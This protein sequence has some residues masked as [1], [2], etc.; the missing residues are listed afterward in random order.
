M[1]FGRKFDT[2]NVNSGR[3]QTLSGIWLGSTP[4]GKQK[5]QNK[6][7]QKKKKNKMNDFICLE[8]IFLSIFNIF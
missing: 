7:T 6:N 5:S 1:L 8:T 4:R 3:Q 2:L